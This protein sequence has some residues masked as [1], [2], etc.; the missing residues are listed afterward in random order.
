VYFSILCSYFLTSDFRTVL[1]LDDT[2]AL[3]SNHIHL[4]VDSVHP[5][6]EVAI[7][8]GRCERMQEGNRHHIKDLALD[9]NVDV[10]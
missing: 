4:T 3:I 6:L 10:Y 9:A 5:R 7:T 8:A 2:V 1:L